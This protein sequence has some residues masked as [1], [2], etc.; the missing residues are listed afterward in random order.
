MGWILTPQST[1]VMAEWSGSAGLAR[2]QSPI[3]SYL[4]FSREALSPVR[5]AKRDS[6]PG[7]FIKTFPQGKKTKKNRPHPCHRPFFFAFINLSFFPSNLNFIFFTPSPRSPTI[8]ILLR[9]APQVPLLTVP[10]CCLLLG[11]SQGTLLSSYCI[12]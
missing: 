11:P 10:V 7:P 6:L 1:Q 12:Q 8:T 5:G 9:L 2:H 4:S 3:L